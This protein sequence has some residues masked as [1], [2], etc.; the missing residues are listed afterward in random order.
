[1]R[2]S[3]IGGALVVALG[4]LVAGCAEEAAQAPAAAGISPQSF[5]DSLFA[6]MNADRANYTT[7]IVARLGPQGAGV[8]APGEHWQDQP[9]GAP[10][11]EAS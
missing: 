2:G 6:V 1:M 5:T 4:T 8:I 9:N 3:M 11:P 7:Q 10:L